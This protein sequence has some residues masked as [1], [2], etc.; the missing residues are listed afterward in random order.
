V[1]R[2]M[3]PSTPHGPF[4]SP[5]KLVAQYPAKRIG[6]T[7]D[8]R[9][10]NIMHRINIDVINITGRRQERKDYFI[11]DNEEKLEVLN[12]NKASRERISRSELRGKRF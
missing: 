12:K 8:L 2:E 6:V 3:I 5:F 7:N 10:Y 1:L 11:A 9:I 4:V